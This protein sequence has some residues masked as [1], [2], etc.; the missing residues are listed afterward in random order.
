M[1]LPF[2][3]SSIAMMSSSSGAWSTTIRLAHAAPPPHDSKLPA[4]LPATRDPAAPPPKHDLTRARALD[5][6]GAKAYGEQRYQDAIKFFDEAHKLGGPPFELWNVAK[7]YLR[8]DLPEPAADYLERYLAT[9]NLPKEDREEASQQLEQL[10]KRPSPLTVNSTPSGAQVAID[11]NKI[12]GRTPITTT[13]P[14]G[15]HTITVSLATNAPY[16][17]KVDAKF[18]R[19]I[20][21]DAPLSSGA[22]EP[23]PGGG[24]TTR[25]PPPENPYFD[26][27]A[28]KIALRGAFGIVLPKFGSIGG[29]A[30]L[31]LTGMG[32]YRF[33][34]AGSVGLAAGGLITVSGD[35]WDNR[36]GE[37]N[38]VRDCQQGPLPDSQSGTALSFFAILTGTFPITQK[39]HAVGIGGAGL[40]GYFV[41]NVGGD[42]FVPSCRASPGV[43]PAI[44]LGSRI[45]YAMTSI[46]RL[47][48]FPLMFQIQPAFDG[49][50]AAPRDASGVWMRFGIGI[51][52]GVDL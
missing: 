6:E 7:C 48:A 17:Q 19:A 9:A 45:D 33:T 40:A 52:A 10:K 5:R 23:P 37:L 50:R 28:N 51:G 16:T 36:T 1:L 32:T 8:L 14:S 27:D 30:G 34:T 39:L 11:G 47:S 20:V 44:L 2:S 25:P 38:I 29:G 49:T 46:L 24:D 35:S 43:R 26:M 13:I 18:G 42:L 15:S 31:G 12:E 41:D 4:G 22:T 21:V 3:F